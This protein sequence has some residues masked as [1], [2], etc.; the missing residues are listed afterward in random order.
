MKRT[1]RTI[2]TKLP[3]T[4]KNDVNSLYVSSYEITDSPLKNN[5]NKFSKA[6][7]KKVNAI[8]E[9][10]ITN[11]EQ[12]IE[13]LLALKERYPQAPVLYNYLSLAYSKIGNRKATSKLVME[14]YLIN[15]D[16]LFAKINY[17]QLCLEKGEVGKIPEIFD[18]KF[19]LKLLYPH[20]NIF[21]VTEFAGFTGVM[22][23]YYCSIGNLDTA[24]I[25]F[26]VLKEIAPESLMVNYAKHFLHPSMITKLQR[27]VYKKRWTD[28]NK[29]ESKEQKEGH[30][31]NFEA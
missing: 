14:N 16:Y 25:L 29:L 12:A 7:Q 26:D 15:P 31:D 27:W 13:K 21:H 20:R 6:D 18:Q 4:L 3:A 22:C 30:S 11:P 28:S 1:Q 17:A 9:I 8:F 24:K 5:E 19:D 23:A 10:L 2:N